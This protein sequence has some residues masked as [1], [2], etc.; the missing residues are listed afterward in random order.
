MQK[1][2]HLFVPSLSL[3]KLKYKLQGAFPNNNAATSSPIIDVS[4]RLTLSRQFSL[5]FSI[6]ILDTG[7]LQHQ[8]K[9]HQKTEP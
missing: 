6:I 3:A 8:D 9:N 2:P 5:S 1:S 4:I 7:Y